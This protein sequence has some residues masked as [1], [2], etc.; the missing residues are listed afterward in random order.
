MDISDTFINNTNL[1]RLHLHILGLN[2]LEEGVSQFM[3]VITEDKVQKIVEKRKVSNSKEE[4]KRWATLQK[5]KRD[6]RAAA[7]LSASRFHRFSIAGLVSD[8]SATFASALS[9]SAPFASTGSAVSML[10]LSVSV[11]F[12]WVC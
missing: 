3:E 10:C 6:A 5:E 12:R 4:K 1:L 7:R 11:C 9:V 2:Y 8:S